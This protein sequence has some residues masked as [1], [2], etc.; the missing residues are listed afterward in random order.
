MPTDVWVAVAELIT[1]I[2][3]QIASETV[4]EAVL[5]AAL[6]APIVT[7]VGVGIAAGA[8]YSPA[9]EIVPVVADPPVIPFTCQVT[10]WLTL[11]VTVAVN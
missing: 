7:E 9:D 1:G 6:M 4:A 2:G 5:T 3:F 8:V 11:F 10:A